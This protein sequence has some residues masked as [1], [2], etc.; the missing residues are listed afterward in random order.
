MDVSTDAIIIESRQ[1]K[2]RSQAL[3]RFV[4][5]NCDNLDGST[6][7]IIALVTTKRD[8]YILQASTI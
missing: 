5:G 6:N 3:V 7:E 4:Q 8:K 2:Q 1:E